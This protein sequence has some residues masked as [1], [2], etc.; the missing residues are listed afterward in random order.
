MSFTYTYS[1]SVDFPQG[2]AAGQFASEVE[3]SSIGTNFSRVDT[4]GD[5]CYVIFSVALT[6]PEETTL[7]GLVAAHVPL[8]SN[9]IIET[10]GY[11]QLISNLADSQ[12]IQIR[13]MDT[14]GGIYAYAGAGGIAFDTTNALTVTCGATIAISNTAGNI[15]FDTPAL[16][17]I[18]G[19][20]GVNI[21]NEAVAAPVNVGTGAAAKTITVGNSTGATAIAL[22]SGTGAITLNSTN[23]TANSI[24]IN[25]SGGI[26]TSVAGVINLATSNA[27]GSAITL[28]AAFGGGGVVLSAGSQGIAINA[29][30]GLIGIGHWSGGDISVGTAAVARTITIGNS[31]GATTLALTTGSGGVAMNSTGA[32]VINSSGSTLNLGTFADNFAVN[33]GTGGSRVTTIGNT[34]ASSAVN[35]VSGSFGATFGNDGSGGEIQIAASANAKTIRVGNT[36]GGSRIF[37]KWGTGGHITYQPSPT[38]LSDADATLTIANLLAGLFT[39]SPSVDRSLTLPTAALAVAGISSVSVDDCIDFYIMH[40]STGAADPVINIIMGGGGTAVGNMVIAPSVNN[41]GTYNYSGTGMFR[42]RFTNVGS[43]TE[44]YSVYRI[45]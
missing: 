43:G 20:S 35:I 32:V 5:D 37:H 17:N 45:A 25:S 22:Y 1:I 23:S 24:Q 38:A 40:L 9:T 29:A 15:T 12:S 26:T 7:D 3:A 2:L 21:G 39:I 33:I 8:A 27:T 34:N 28:D 4:L 30:S 41:A 36:T 14:N 19:D 31:T 6:A 18:N 42:M 11:L 16:I 44:A 10:D 13:A